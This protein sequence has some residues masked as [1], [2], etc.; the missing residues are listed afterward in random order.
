MPS[1]LLNHTI[2]QKDNPTV[3]KQRNSREELL[4]QEDFSPSVLRF[5]VLHMFEFS[6]SMSRGSPS[7]SRF[8]H[9]I[10]FSH[11]SGQMRAIT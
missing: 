1:F 7:F 10:V 6:A 9:P 5:M 4:Q 3:V 2:Y 8:F 11:S